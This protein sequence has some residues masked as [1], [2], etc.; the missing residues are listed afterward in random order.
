MGRE[1]REAIIREAHSLGARAIL[2]TGGEPLL[3][4]HIEPLA[5]LARDLGLSVQ[6]ATN[7]LGLARAGGWLVNCVDEL[8]VSF[9]GPEPVYDSLRGRGMFVRLAASVEAIVGEPRRPRLVARAVVSSRNAATLYETAVSA[10]RLGF[11]AVSFL[12][13]DASSEAF[14]GDP[15]SRS[16][17]AP[18]PADVALLHASIDRLAA[19]GELGGFVLEDE[20]KMRGLA[21]FLGADRSS[22]QAP[23]CNAPEWSSVVEAD[24]GVRPCFFQ[25]VASNV[26]DQSL[27][28][29]RASAAYREAL[30]RLGPGNP[31]CASC[32]C[33]K[34]VPSGPALIAGRVKALLGRV[35]PGPSSKAES[36]A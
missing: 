17:L 32:V 14:G 18:G 8:Y 25:P 23:R 33:P 10:R 16:S 21:A 31:V 35:L 30:Q 28:G 6:I 20:R 4:D 22:S 34:H 27:R 19:A 1:E 26:R 24:G 12:A 3:C 9:E 13:V 36:P 29:A 5:R 11:D 15:A 2:F 7:G